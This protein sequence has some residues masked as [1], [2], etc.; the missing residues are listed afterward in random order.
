VLALVTDKPKK[1]LGELI[2]LQMYF[3]V[4]RINDDLAL[5]PNPTSIHED[6][7]CKG[8]AK[9]RLVED[10]VKQFGSSPKHRGQRFHKDKYRIEFRIILSNL[11]DAHWQ[12][13]QLLYSRDSSG[14][15]QRRL[16][17]IDFLTD[18]NLVANTVPKGNEFGVSSWLIANPELI[19]LLNLY[20]AKI[21]PNPN[22]SSIE[23]RRRIKTKNRKTKKY[24]ILPKPERKED[25]LKHDR[26]EA[27]TDLINKLLENHIVTL[28]KT[29]IVS[30]LTRKFN[31]SLA[32]GGRFY[33]KHFQT[34]T[35]ENRAKL[36]IDGEQTVEPDFSAMHLAILYAMKGLQID[37]DTAY[38][39]EGFERSVAKAVVLRAVNIKSLTSLESIITLSA[40]P[41][42]QAKYYAH[43]EKRIIY[44]LRRAKG[45]KCKEPY[46]EEWMESFIEGIPVG[47]NAKQLIK[48][49]SERHSAIFDLIGSKD[50]GLR[51]QAID[52]E[53]VAL[54]LTTLEVKR[55]PALP[56]HDSVIVK[57]R[58]KAITVLTMMLAF[59]EISKKISPNGEGFKARVKA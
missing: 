19:H 37:Y 40:N 14:S 17:A 22:K 20:E 44:D 47:T 52:S 29:I 53:I 58:N 41:D 15:N 57:K 16:K 1:Q 26:L 49:F 35:K 7:Y 8:K 2:Q 4:M 45:L 38:D 55:I 27:E 12:K 11:L 6:W 36:L 59:N 18:L 5:A 3:G 30:Y 50:L 33:T 39:F 28:D 51:L 48:A 24:K 34:L 56:V 9:N 21:V 43:K 42:N 31:E 10:M 25:R 54:V 46:K 32:L 13:R 23:I